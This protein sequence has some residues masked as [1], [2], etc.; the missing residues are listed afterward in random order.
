MRS[1]I[2]SRDTTLRERAEYYWRELDRDNLTFDSREQLA[3]AVS[4]VELD[5][6]IETFRTQLLGEQRRHLVVHA[7]SEQNEQHAEEATG[8]RLSQQL[9]EDR[10]H[11]QAMLDSFPG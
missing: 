9:I 5:E 6:L 11:F 2:L 3:T 10:E 4:A 1:R 8:E 7:R